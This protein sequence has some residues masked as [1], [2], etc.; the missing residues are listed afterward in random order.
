MNISKDK[1]L[2][3]LTTLAPLAKAGRTTLPILSMVKIDGDTL[4]ASN[5]DEWATAR[6]DGDGKAL[7]PCCVSLEQFF[8]FARAASDEIALNNEKDLLVVQSMTGTARLKTMPAAEHVKFPDEKLRKI[9]VNCADLAEC[10]ERVAWAAADD[11]DTRFVIISVHVVLSDTAIMAE[12][13]CG[14]YIA[15]MV[16]PSIAAPAEFLLPSKAVAAFL[17]ALRSDGAVLSVGENYASVEHS[18]GQHWARL[19]N[20]QFP[21]SHANEIIET[22]RHDIGKFKATDWLKPI[23]SASIIQLPGGQWRHGLMKLDSAGASFSFK[24]ATGQRFNA[25]VQGQFQRADLNISLE[26]WNALLPRFG[27]CEATLSHNETSFAV[28]NGEL[29]VVASKT[30]LPIEDEPTKEEQCTLPLKKK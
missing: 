21:E 12:S 14:K 7:E 25:V 9:G 28:R 23:E 6:L 1:L 19:I 26:L 5:L 17:V 30:M 24:S 29:T 11:S 16:K 18:S 3:A 2:S 22:E 10:I 27:D 4:S 8:K 15:R 20:G 13:T